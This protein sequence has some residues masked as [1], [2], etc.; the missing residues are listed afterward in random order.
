MDASKV[1]AN[2]SRVAAGFAR[3]RAARQRR[4]GL[5][6]ADFAALTEAG[7]LLTGVP[8]DQG[9]L[10]RD[11]ASST[12]P[13]SE[14]LRVLG[15]A[16][17]SLALVC[18]MHP[19]VISFWLAQPP[20]PAAYAAAWSE[21]LRWVASTALAGHVWGTITSEPG[22]GG[23][24]A[25]SRA[26]ARKAG[27]G[28]GYLLSGQKH[29][30]SG[31]GITS[32]MITSAVAE[33]DAQA[34]WFFFDARDKV[35][36]GSTGAKLIAEWDGQGM[37][38]TQSHAFEFSSFPVTRFAWPENLR[39]ATGAAGAFV[40]TLFTAVVV[41]VVE[42]AIEQAREAMQKRKD[43]LRAYEQV[44]W[45]RAENEA[46]LIVQAFEGM[47]RAIEANGSAALLE[48]LRGKETIAELAESV[49]RRI[50]NVVGGGAYN[51]SSPFGYYFED[52]RALGFLRPP[53][54]LAFDQLLQ[55]SNEEHASRL[56][57]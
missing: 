13:I 40:C 29:F 1:L 44:E 31:S 7:F 46:W 54:G 27:S 36:D 17:P 43:S 6:R 20:A 12:R 30:G 23:D 49:T 3:D 5:E 41:G 21:Q 35:W 26:I 56:A 4:R 19:A 33:G 32:Y 10:W 51:R 48:A 8:E 25:R 9:G 16:D 22:S 24:V 28:A 11:V 34:D 52:V 15:R 47:R 55:W 45:V 18:S 37:A 39:G 57:K 38:A 42:T 50:C 14:L 2:V 53:W